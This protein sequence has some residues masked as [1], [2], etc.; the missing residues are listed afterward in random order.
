[1]KRGDLLRH[2]RAHGCDLLREGGHV[3]PHRAV[4]ESGV[5]N[6]IS[7]RD[8]YVQQTNP[9]DSSSLPSGLLGD[10]EVRSARGRG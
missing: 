1:M 3:G 7:E 4:H 6:D 10:I 8:D 2:L 5:H 9:P